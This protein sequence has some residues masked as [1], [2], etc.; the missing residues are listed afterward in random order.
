[1][2]PR[3]PQHL[4]I[5]PPVS[6]TMDRVETA[7]EQLSSLQPALVS[8]RKLSLGRTLSLS[9]SSSG[10]SSSGISTAGLEQS[11]MLRWVYRTTSRGSMPT[12]PIRRLQER[13]GRDFR[14]RQGV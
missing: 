8:R 14:R 3:A 4:V 12:T 2:K 13:Y 11:T 1:G 10:I 5:Q 6:R 9:R 7:L